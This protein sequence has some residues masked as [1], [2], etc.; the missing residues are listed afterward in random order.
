MR[1][2]ALVGR[3]GPTLHTRRGGGEKTFNNL[4]KNLRRRMGMGIF[5]W[6]VKLD[7]AGFRPRESL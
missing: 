4:N 3:G 2:Y 7:F 5:W 1:K 6:R